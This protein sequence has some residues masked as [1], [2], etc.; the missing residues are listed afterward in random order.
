MTDV[1]Y[2]HTYIYIARIAVPFMW[3]SLRLAPVSALIGKLSM[4]HL[5]LLQARLHCICTDHFM[6]LPTMSYEHLTSKF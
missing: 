6:L 1:P 5:V 2:I 4:L 3:G